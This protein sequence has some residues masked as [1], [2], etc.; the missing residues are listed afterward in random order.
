MKGQQRPAQARSAVGSATRWMATL[1]AAH[2]KLS[3]PPCVQVLVCSV[4]LGHLMQAAQCSVS[5][6]HIISI[7]PQLRMRTERL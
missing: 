6:M 5:A 2:L 7:K 3:V 1:H 4:E